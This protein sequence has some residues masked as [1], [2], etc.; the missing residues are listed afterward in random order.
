MTETMRW[1]N[2]LRRVYEET[3]VPMSDAQAIELLSGHPDSDEFIEEYR[4]WRATNSDVVRGPGPHGRGVLRRAPKGPVP[5]LAAKALT[6][7]LWHHC[8]G[9]DIHPAEK[10]CGRLL[11]SVPQ[12]SEKS[13]SRKLADQARPHTPRYRT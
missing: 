4:R 5:K 3:P 7:P 1:Y 13:S 6:A 2:P 9:P 12:V 10:V 11:P 8:S